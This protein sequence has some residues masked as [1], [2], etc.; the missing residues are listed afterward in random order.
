MEAVNG[1]EGEVIVEG[2]RLEALHDGEDGDAV[3]PDIPGDVVDLPPTHHSSM[4][5]HWSCG[6]EGVQVGVGSLPDSVVTRD[7]EE[8]LSCTWWRSDACGSTPHVRSDAGSCRCEHSSNYKM[9]PLPGCSLL[10][11]SPR[12]L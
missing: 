1:G 3:S 6:G 5:V 9:P 7:L 12:A 4:Q 2:I 8:Y 10:R 11:G